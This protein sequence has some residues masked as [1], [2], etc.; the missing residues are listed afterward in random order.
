MRN[1]E[2]SYNLKDR[3]NQIFKEIEVYSSQ[4]LH[5]LAK[6]RCVELAEMV[7][8]SAQLTHKEAL[9]EAISRKINSIE[10]DAINFEG[11][12]KPRKMSSNELDI[13][14][15]LV[16][17]SGEADN[18]AATWEV[19][20]ACLILRQYDKALL[21]FN[22]LIDNRYK[23]VPSAK[24]VLRCCIG[25]SAMDDA[26]G[27]YH[28]WFL[29]GIFSLDQLENIRTF[30]QEILYKKNINTLLSKPRQEGVDH[31][32]GTPDDEYIDIIEVKLCMNG[33]SGEGKETTLEVTHQKGETFNVVVPKNN[34][35]LLDYLKIGKDIK[36]LELYSS[37]IIFTDQ[38]RVCEKSKIKSGERQGDYSVCMSIMK[39][40]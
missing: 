23:L 11:N 20:K 22:R 3:I 40:D 8:G 33:D 36:S 4:A 5:S 13:V 39:S 18:D 34:Q 29:S 26:I 1:A 14:K 24:N 35:A 31:E 2:R 37:S 28:E 19:A 30:L 25:M 6:Q 12:G 17:V 9:L 38:C 15:R 10:E 27:K 21:E 7:K 32:Q 16:F